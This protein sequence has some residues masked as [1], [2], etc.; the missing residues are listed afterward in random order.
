MQGIFPRDIFT[1]FS[2]LNVLALF[3]YSYIIPAT[4]LQGLSGGMWEGNTCV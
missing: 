2:I 3:I 1:P 4:P